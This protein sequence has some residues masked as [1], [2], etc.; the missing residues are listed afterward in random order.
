[1]NIINEKP[2]SHILMEKDGKWILTLLIYQGPV[3]NDISILFN[4]NEISQLKADNSYIETLLF[5]IRNNLD[6]YKARQIHP[7]VWP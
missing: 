7:P 6:A 4:D 3:E 5:K 1:M 2:W